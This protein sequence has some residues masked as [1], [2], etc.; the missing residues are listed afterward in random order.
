MIG[1]R[2]EPSRRGVTI[3]A[4]NQKLA[5]LIK[6]KYGRNVN[7]RYRYKTNDL[8]IFTDN[9]SVVSAKLENQTFKS[10]SVIE[11]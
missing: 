4:L 8:L 11:S 2:S 1:H 9:K 5:S 10:K 3:F 6:F 7:D